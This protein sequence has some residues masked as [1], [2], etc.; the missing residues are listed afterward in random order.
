MDGAA[1]F[2]GLS[3][4]S[5]GGMA[6]N[7]LASRCEGTIGIGQERTVLVGYQKARNDS[8]HSNLRAELRCHF[9]SHILGV[10]CD[11]GLGTTISEDACQRTQCRLRAEIDD[12]TFFLL[13]E[14]RTEDFRWQDSAK[15]V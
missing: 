13:T 5:R 6:D 11:G 7:F 3:K 2:F 14:N 12:S 15:E 10:T 4:A 8:I 1:E 9:G